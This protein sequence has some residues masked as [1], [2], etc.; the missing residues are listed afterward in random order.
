MFSKTSSKRLLSNNLILD[1]LKGIIIALLLSLGLIILFAFSLKWF[2][3]PDSF[4][5][6]F[7]LAIKGISVLIGSIFAVKGESKGLIKGFGFGAIYIVFAFIIFSVLSGG[8]NFSFN[9]LLDMLFAGL[10]GGMVG[11]IKVNKT[12]KI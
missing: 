1:F 8:F 5:P 2:N 9:S 10:L 11:I 7:T 6:S 12:S 4:I 3:I